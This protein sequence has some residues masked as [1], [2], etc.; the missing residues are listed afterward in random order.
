MLGLGEPGSFDSRQ[1]TKPSVIYD[2]LNAEA[3]F[4][5]WYAAEDETK[6]GVGLRDLPGRPHLD[7]GRRGAASGQARDARQLPGDAAVRAH[8]QRRVLH[9]VHGRRREEPPRR[10]RHVRRRPGLAARRRRVRRGHRQL[11]RGRVRAGG[12]AHRDRLPHAVHRQQ[13]RRRRRHPEQAHQRGQPDGLTWAAGNIAF[14]AS[15]SDTA[16]DGYNVSQPTILSDPADAAHPYKMWY[17]GN[18][19]D[20]NGNYHDRI[21]LA[22]QKSPGTVTQ[23]V[24]AP[25]AAGDPYYES[26]LT[27]GT[28]GTAFDTMKVADLRP[29]AKPASAGTGLYGFYTGTNAADFVSRIG[30]K[31]SSDDGL[32]W[33]DAGTHATLIDKGTAGAFDEGGV[34]CPAPV[35]DPAGGWWVYHT[36]LTLAGTPSIGLHT[37]PDDLSYADAEPV[38]GARLRRRLRRRRSGGPVRRRRRVGAGAV[39]RR[40]GRGRHVVHRRRRRRTTAAP[41]TFSSARQV[42]APTPG[43]YAYDAGGL[44]HPVAHKAPDGSWR[45][46]YTAIGADGV[47]RIAYATAPADLSSWTQ[48]RP[49]HGRLS[50]R[51][52]LHRG[53]RGAERRVGARPGRRGALLHRHRPLRL[54]ARRQSHGRRRR[55]RRERLRHLRARRRQRARLAAD[56]C[57]PRPRC[58]QAPRARST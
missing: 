10:L 20:V 53:R 40:Q 33:T 35:A 57:G 45:L 26:V 30:V 46:F 58:R 12:R 44:R 9:V 24:K 21:G 27:L 43:T 18:N 38:A 14:S 2:P 41:A 5:M 56:R 47:R 1:L 31:E 8:R 55:L 7:Q 15:G 29:V 13:G 19:P 37:V 6:G 54:D 32:T 22:Y 36:S 11:Q 52:R 16:F 17:V 4:R 28:Q 25:G 23:W 49:R 51:L 42:L 3:P 50:G 48:A 34:A 39:L